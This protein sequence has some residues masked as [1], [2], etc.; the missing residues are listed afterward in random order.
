MLA[1]VV[2]L[3]LGDQHSMILKQD[4][5]VWS[6]PIHLRGLAYG[7][8]RFAQVILSG[9]TAVAAGTG[10][11]MVLKQDGSFWAM[12]RNYHGQLGDGTR[13]RQDKFFFVQAIPG[14][15]AI[16]AGASHSMVLTQEGSVS[17]A[18][19]NKYGQLGDGSKV[20]Y[21]TKFSVTIA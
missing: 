2:R 20:V 3:A 21:M 13:M 9:A 15:K 17:L 7:D 18:G 10:F 12:G 5:S 11:S 19:S 14:A 1:D 8:N 6:T 4:G 16:A